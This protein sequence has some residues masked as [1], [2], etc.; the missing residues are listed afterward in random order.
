EVERA[1]EALVVAP[2]LDALHGEGRALTPAAIAGLCED[3]PILMAP[4]TGGPAWPAT[5][6]A[7]VARCLKALKKDRLV[8][9]HRNGTWSPTEKGLKTHLRPTDQAGE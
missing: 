1:Y 9:M 2:F 6:K 7:Q 3:E 5:R 8:K 4:S